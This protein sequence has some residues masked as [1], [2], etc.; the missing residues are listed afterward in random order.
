M[1]ASTTA[2][3]AAAAA[4]LPTKATASWLSTISATVSDPPSLCS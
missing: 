1:A 2:A 3:A 4:W